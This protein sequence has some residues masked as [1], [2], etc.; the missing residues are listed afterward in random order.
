MP[1]HDYYIKIIVKAIS[2]ISCTPK[3]FIVREQV[4]NGNCTDGS[5]CTCNSKESDAFKAFVSKNMKP[6]DGDVIEK[7]INKRDATTEEIEKA[8]NSTTIVKTTTEKCNSPELKTIILDGIIPDDPN[9]SKR[10]IH[11]T[12][13]EILSSADQFNSHLDVICSNTQFSF[14]IATQLFCEAS[15]S[16]VTCFLYR[17]IGT[18][19]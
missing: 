1:A 15:K 7:R 6:I 10:K 8:D 19:N 5:I 14:R 13:N 9:E 2:P 11:K 3:Y 12:A 18:H 16:N 4:K 17:Q